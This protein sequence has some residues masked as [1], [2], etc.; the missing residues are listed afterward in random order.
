MPAPTCIISLLVQLATSM[1]RHR[2]L[3]LGYDAER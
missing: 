3:G 2:G 1:D